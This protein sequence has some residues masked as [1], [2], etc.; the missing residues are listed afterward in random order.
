MR[1]EE[2]ET[3]AILVMDDDAGL[4][5]EMGGWLAAD[6]VRIAQ[7]PD[8]LRGLEMASSGEYVLVVLGTI[9]RGSPA[10]FELLRRLAARAREPIILLTPRPEE[11]DRILGLELGADDCLSRPFNPRELL[12]RIHA[13][14]RRGRA[15]APAGESPAVL[16]VGDVVLEPGRRVARRKGQPLALTSAEFSLLEILVKRV[17]RV[18]RREEITLQVLG[19]AQTAQDRCIDTHVSRLRKKLGAGKTGAGRIETIRNVGYL[20]TSPPDG[21]APEG[22]ESRPGVPLEGDL[23]G[24][25]GEIP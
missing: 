8:A 1:G 18:V 25:Q 13:L 6:G 10:G 19:R 2:G 24:A 4:W 23:Q 15:G 5:E 16:A 9:S 17:G 20:Y 22:G 3:G 12:A 14:L 7:A 11:L 21:D